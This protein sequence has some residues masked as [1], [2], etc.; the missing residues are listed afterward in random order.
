MEKIYKN[1]EEFLIDNETFLKENDLITTLLTNN[2]KMNLETKPSVG[3][4]F[5]KISNDEYT[6][7]F[8]NYHPYDMLVVGSYNDSIIKEAVDFIERHN[9]MIYGIQAE[10]NLAYKLLTKLIE[11]KNLTFSTSFKMAIMAK[12]EMIEVN[13]TYPFIRMTNEHYN[14]LFDLWRSFSYEIFNTLPLEEDTKLRV[15][16]IINSEAYGIIKDHKVVSL[17]V[18]ARDLE[19]TISIS[20]VITL[21]EYRNQ[22]FAKALVNYA[23][24]LIVSKGKKAVLYVDRNNPISNHVYSSIGFKYII[25]VDSYKLHDSEK[26]K[27]AVFAGG[28]FWCMSKPYYDFDGVIKVV[29]GYTGGDEISPTYDEV[30]H[31]NTHHTEAIKVTYDEGKIT[32]DQLLE[33]YLDNIDPFDGE[34]QFIDRGHNYRPII[35]YTNDEQLIK[36]TTA[37]KNLENKFN[38]EVMVKVEK[39]NIFY[40]AEEYH[41]NFAVKYPEKIK[42]EFLDSKRIEKP[43]IAKVKKNDKFYELKILDNKIIEINEVSD[44]IIYDNPKS[45]S[46][47]ITKFL[48]E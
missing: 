19:T 27:N 24:N 8:G 31:L 38:K 23:S 28:C 11:Q 9:L 20:N 3:C 2:A 6:L 17:V 35:F 13:N 4:L 14:D 47:I 29:S 25:N 32:Y 44:F 30:K 40:E 10:C 12:D 22:G 45:V 41:Q 18:L 1:G 43:I 21:K 16:N 39:I 36:I 7:L 26:I 46:E 48:N 42:K 15:E 34:G 37:L 33:I 5:F